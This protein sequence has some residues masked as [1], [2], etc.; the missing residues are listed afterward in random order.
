LTEFKKKLTPLDF[1]LYTSPPDYPDKRLFINDDLCFLIETGDP[2]N[3]LASLSDNSLAIRY[4]SSKFD[5][6]D[7]TLPR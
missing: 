1:L 5:V 2:A 7:V 6:P 3:K 4:I